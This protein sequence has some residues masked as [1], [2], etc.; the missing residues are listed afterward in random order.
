MKNYINEIFKIKNIDQFNDLSLK[1]YDYQIKNSI[2]YRDFVNNLGIAKSNINSFID[3]PFLPVEFYKA[4]EI[5]TFKYNKNNFFE[6][7]GTNSSKY[8]SCHFINDYKL[9]EKSI[10]DCFRL[11]FGEPQKYIFLS[12]VPDNSTHPNSSL[13]YMMKF[14]VKISESKQSGFYLGNDKK[15]CEIIK[16][17]NNDKVI[18]LWGLSYALLDFSEKNKLNTKNIIV[19]ETGGMKG[20][21]KEI[22]KEELYN[23]LKNNLKVQEIYSEYSM[24]ELTSQAYSFSNGK[25]F[26]PPWL[27]VIITEIND[28]KKILNKGSG[29]INIIDLANIYSCPFIATKDI[30]FINDDGS[31]EVLGRFDHSDIRGCSL[32]YNK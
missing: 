14:L 21:R 18:F 31:F 25:F 27:K 26:T 13:S 28:Y 1:A 5:V 22:T 24:S 3:I 16:N 11:F 32:L 19:L 23:I 8:K 30:G 7:S 9:Y 12:L 15:V 2:V 10:L 6:S 29:L 17:S 4:K 20:K